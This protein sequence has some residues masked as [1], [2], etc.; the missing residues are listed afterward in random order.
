[1][2]TILCP[3]DFSES[4]FSAIEFASR[5]G[6][7][8]ISSIE[9]LHVI[10][11][12]DLDTILENQDIDRS[13]EE[14]TALIHEKMNKLVENIR[15]EINPELNIH[16]TI[17]E[18]ELIPLILDTESEKYIDLIV[19][20]TKG[21]SDIT[22]EYF[23]SNTLQVIK[24]CSC[25]VFCIPGGTSFQEID[26]IVYAYNY[27]EED[28]YA[29]KE[30]I[31]LAAS[32][33]ARV[34]VLHIVA[35]EKNQEDAHATSPAKNIESYFES[36]DVNFICKPYKGSV[37]DGINAYLRET[38]ADL[39]AILKRKR[40]FIEDLFHKSITRYFAYYTDIPVLIF[41]Y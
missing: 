34:D 40:N 17:R 4:S 12:K 13:F 20:G 36:P 5:L 21:V 1:M 16:Y 25:P 8:L 22:E 7:K 15:E 26:K 39:L 28:I 30:V 38:G 10:T 11:E 29:L 14:K 41:K 31:T 18:G 27:A 2:K 23:G 33:H 19:M 35:H 37:H 3:V 32:I 24:Q 6:E 9:L